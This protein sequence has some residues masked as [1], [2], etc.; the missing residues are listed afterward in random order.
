MRPRCY[1]NR[2]PKVKFITLKEVYL[3]ATTHKWVKLNIGMTVWLANC[4]RGK[5]LVE[6]R[7]T[8]R[9]KV[10]SAQKRNARR[11]GEQAAGKTPNKGRMT[12]WE[13]GWNK[14]KRRTNYA[15]RGGKQHRHN[16]N[17]EKVNQH[18][19]KLRR[20]GWKRRAHSARR[21]RIQTGSDAGWTANDKTGNDTNGQKL[22]VDDARDGEPA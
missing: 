5:V 18:G 14:V 13:M 11:N 8:R 22:W 20:M 19:D 7:S 17:A 4:Q 16:R 2:K 1:Q 10:V 6:Y 3:H 9:K 21:K 15:R 12:Q